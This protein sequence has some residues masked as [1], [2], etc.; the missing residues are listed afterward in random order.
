MAGK[1][2]I[3][4]A[5][6][7][8]VSEEYLMQDDAG[9]NSAVP[10]LSNLADRDQMIMALLSH[11]F[12][13]GQVA[14]AFC[15]TQG[16]V[17]KIVKRIDPAGFFSLGDEA[18]K[19]FIASRARS[20]TVEALSLLSMES[21]RECTPVQIAKIAKTTAEIS[22]IQERKDTNNFGDKKITKLIVEFVDEID[23][24]RPIMEIIE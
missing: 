10:D 24:S 1:K 16:A 13:Q 6:L 7:L 19:A 15:L 21:M 2:Q 23:T 5:E 3:D 11:G 4:A 20:M 9:L 14:E 22:A 12:S 8:D 18:K 17:S